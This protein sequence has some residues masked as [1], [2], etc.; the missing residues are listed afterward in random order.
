MS[1]K[2]TLEC[3]RKEAMRFRVGNNFFCPSKCH[4]GVIQVVGSR[5]KRESVKGPRKKIKT[6]FARLGLFR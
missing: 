4:T 5:R 2:Y 1:Q 3:T 6:L